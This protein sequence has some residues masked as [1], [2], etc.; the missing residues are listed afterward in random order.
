M[1]VLGGRHQPQ[2]V[3][4]VPRAGSAGRFAA[5]LQALQ[6]VLADRLQHREARLAV[7]PGPSAGAGSGPPGRQAIE[8]GRSDGGRHRRRS[9]APT[10][11][12]ASAA[13]SVQPP[14]NTASRRSSRCSPAESRSWLQASAARSVWW[15]AGRSR[16]P[17]RQQLEPARPAAPGA[18]AAAAASAAPRPA[19]APAAARPAARTPRPPPRRSAPSARSR[20]APPAPAPPAAPPPAPPPAPPGRRAARGPA[21][22]AAAPAYSC[23][24]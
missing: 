8:D 18:P 4:G 24:P 14:A 9:S 11:Q 19:R 1:G 5:G 2:I 15:R 22:P 17:P 13:S 12:T 21:A 23:S 3:L 6:A 16:A 20:A 10:A 7:R